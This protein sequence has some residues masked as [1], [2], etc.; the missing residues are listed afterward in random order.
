[1]TP[2][3]KE[4]RQQLL[5]FIEQVLAPEEAVK[6]VVGIG[7]IASGHMRPDSDI[8][9]VIFLDPFDLF[10]VPA[11]SWWNPTDGSYHSIFEEKDFSKGL[12]LDFARCNLTEWADPNFEWPEGNRAELSVGWIAYDPSG[13]IASLIAKKTAY[14]DEIRQQRIDEALIWLDQ[15]LTWSDPLKKWQTYDPVI[16]FD[17]LS[18]AYRY[19]VQALFAYN[20]QWQIWRNR[21]MQA[22]L[23][24]TWLPTDF[25]DK[26]LIAAN[27]PSLDEVGYTARAAVLTELFQEL[28]AEL[29]RCGDYSAMPV[30]QAFIRQHREI[31]RAWNMEEWNRFHKIRE[32]GKN[33][34]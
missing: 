32:L 31:G 13:E 18:A 15:H 27:T 28:L 16:A 25:E 14:D 7:S 21:E 11:E 24:L 6:G 3:T 8:D 12:Q 30:D 33:S 10:I 4:K 34:E 29:T 5:N 23:Q 22:L 26:V 20:R 19:L 17:R 1:M 2:A 9:A